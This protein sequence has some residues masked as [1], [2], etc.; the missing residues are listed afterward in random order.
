MQGAP[1]P[2]QIKNSDALVALETARQSSQALPALSVGALVRL[3][4]RANPEQGFG[5]L[6]YRGLLL[7]AVLPDFL[8]TGDSFVARVEDAASP[9]VLKIVDLNKQSSTSGTNSAP[10]APASAE[11]QSDLASLLRTISSFAQESSQNETSGENASIP[12]EAEKFLADL[13]INALENYPQEL[14]KGLEKSASGTLSALLETAARELE[15]TLRTVAA[16]NSL[17]ALRADLGTLLGSKE[18]PRA[19]TQNVLEKLLQYTQEQPGDGRK[20]LQ[21]SIE[22]T[23]TLLR[24]FPA[25]DIREALARVITNADAALTEVNKQ[26]SFSEA[27]REDLTRLSQSLHASASTQTAL[28]RLNPLMQSLGEAPLLFFPFLRDGHFAHAGIVVHPEVARERQ[29]GAGSEGR[30]NP[31]ER[32]ADEHSFR[33]VRVS[34]PLP[35]MGRID[36]DIAYRQNEIMLHITA[37]S[38]EVAQF[39]E[40]H[41]SDLAEALQGIGLELTEFKSRAGAAQDSAPS[42]TSP[43]KPVVVIA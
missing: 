22:A 30:E 33:R 10:A 24:R 4:V 3:E 15:S 34:A 1:A 2:D 11:L 5:T 35:N 29:H 18:I 32:S 8:K 14:A 6:F 9:V 42:W 23:V 12:A 31:Q 36:A 21:K 27:A 28:A 37:P 25:A 43:G 39:F 13:E 40:A 17:R 7:A 20:A 16:I 19:V 38:D 26:Q 41:Y